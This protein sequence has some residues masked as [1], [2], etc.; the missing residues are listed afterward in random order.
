[1]RLILNRFFAYLD[2]SCR[3]LPRSLMMQAFSLAH[4]RILAVFD[5]D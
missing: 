4:R 2:D 3:D 1:M 5:S